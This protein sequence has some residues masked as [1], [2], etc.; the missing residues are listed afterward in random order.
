MEKR[1]GFFTLIELLV[2]I[3]IIAI[4]AG[5]LLP[6]L[7]K[8]RQASYGA[9]CISKLKQIGKASLMYSDDSDGWIAAAYGTMRPDFLNER[10]RPWYAHLQ[11]YMGTGG[12][13]IPDK[14]YQYYIAKLNPKRWCKA[15]PL[16]GLN[17][18]LAWNKQM[19]WSNNSDLF[20][21]PM[22]KMNRV[23]RPSSVFLAA[24][25]SDDI[26]FEEYLPSG[27]VTRRSYSSGTA[28]GHLVFCH[29]QNANILCA[30]GHA[31]GYSFNTLKATESLSTGPF[32]MG[33]AIEQ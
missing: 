19:G 9:D 25:A 21:V 1:C 23:K 28:M 16:S 24:D 7:N 32:K 14:S 4:L 31:A 20:I 12:F 17:T 30:D 13:F 3:A 15:N 27:P 2:V 18:N 33:L 11:N 6:A 8:A 5:M 29:N 10:S 26:K 22:H